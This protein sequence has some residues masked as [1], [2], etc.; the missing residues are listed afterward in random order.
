M[1]NQEI[2]SSQI[3][4]DLY[5]NYEIKFIEKKVLTFRLNQNLKIL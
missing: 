5:I 1:I 3:I 2:G 4:K